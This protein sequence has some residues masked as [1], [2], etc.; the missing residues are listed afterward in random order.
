MWSSQ[1]FLRHIWSSN[2]G[3]AIPVHARQGCSPQPGFG[4]SQA[5]SRKQLLIPQAAESRPRRAF[6][7]HSQR[8]HDLHVSPISL[9]PPDLV[10]SSEATKK[11]PQAKTNFPV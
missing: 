7:H 10:A 3:E 9:G 6:V 4:A 8:A 2:F 5:S 1:Q 11:P